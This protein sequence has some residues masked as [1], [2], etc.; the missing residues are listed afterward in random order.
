MR[1][2]EINDKN[3]IPYEWE[4]FENLEKDLEELLEEN[5]DYILENEKILIIGRQVKTNLDTKID[6]LGL[7]KDGNLVVIELKRDLTPRETLAQILEY[8]SFVKNLSYEDLESIFRNYMGTEDIQLLDQ[9]R[10]YFQSQNDETVSFNKDQKLIIV[11]ERISREIRQTASFLREKGIQIFCVE[12]K[13]FKVSLSNTLSEQS[14][15]APELSNSTHLPSSKG[16]RKLIVFETVVGEDLYPKKIL[17]SSPPR[18]TKEEFLEKLDKKARELFKRVL[19]FAE[20]GGFLIHW[21]TKGFSI[22][23]KIDENNYVNIL[24]GFPKTS[25]YKQDVLVIHF[26]E[27][28]KKVK[29]GEDIVE[30]Y[31]QELSRIDSFKPIEKSMRCAI[32][33]LEKDMDNF[34]DIL[35]RVVDKIKQNGLIE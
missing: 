28:A 14:T 31:K 25:W 12:F 3:L 20:R 26:S 19:D 6:L 34:L 23:A 32:E 8:A 16:D 22:N 7:D 13:I 30:F 10:E 35:S 18:I 5:S 17:S 24:L 11:G 1:I 21:G 15:S 29:N 33:D 4:K 9:H 2:F 27:I